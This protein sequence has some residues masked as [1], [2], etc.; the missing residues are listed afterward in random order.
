LS[1]VKLSAK[2]FTAKKGTT[3]KLTL[4]QAAKIT[5]LITHTAKGHKVNGVCKPNARTGKKCTITTKRTLS[6]TGKAGADIFSLK[7]RGMA[8]GSYTATITAQNANGTSGA[9][10]LAFTITHK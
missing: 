6:F 1:A 4:S 5:V 9:V 8:K 10:K 3:L 7:L 2:R